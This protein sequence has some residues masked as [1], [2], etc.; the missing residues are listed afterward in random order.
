MKISVLP[1]VLSIDYFINVYKNKSKYA[2]LCTYKYVC[3]KS[4]A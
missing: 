3:F 1:K 2:Y 4:L